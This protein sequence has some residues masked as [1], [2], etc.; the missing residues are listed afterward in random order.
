M[1][2]LSLCDLFNLLLFDMLIDVAF[3]RKHESRPLE[4]SP[5]FPAI[6]VSDNCWKSLL[7]G[8]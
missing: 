6:S 5:W 1:T 4:H 8:R 2:S 3:L 7:S